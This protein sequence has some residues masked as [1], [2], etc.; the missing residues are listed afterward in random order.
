MAKRV[1][2]VLS[3][4]GNRDGSEIRETILALLAL[5]R[6]GTR[7]F[8]VAPT[9]AKRP[10]V[11]HLDG[12][13]DPALRDVFAESARLARGRLRPLAEI[14]PD[15]FEALVFPGGAG[16]GTV[17]SNYAEKGAVCDVHPDVVRLLKAALAA[18]KPMGFICLAPILA[19]RVLGPVAGVRVTFGPRAIPAAKHAAIMG[20]DV[21][22]CTPTE[23]VIDQKARVVSTPAYMYEEIRLQEVATAVDK[24]ARAVAQ[25]CRL[26]EGQHPRAPEGQPPRSPR[27]GSSVREVP[28]RKARRHNAI[29][30]GRG[31]A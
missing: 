25:L 26:S 14:S 19:A 29:I 22:P 15:H 9:E 1:A 16:V 18:H 31:S 28:P 3:G 5:E 7:P 20:A 2:V 11:N 6:A 10:A 24:L 21:R 13:V 12:S 4:C 23:V 8:C 27:P 17:L 30:P